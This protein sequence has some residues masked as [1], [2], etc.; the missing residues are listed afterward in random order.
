MHLHSDVK[1]RYLLIVLFR[2][3]TKFYVTKLCADMIT[4]DVS[5]Y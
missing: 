1:N 5:I 2:R 3:N 4:I